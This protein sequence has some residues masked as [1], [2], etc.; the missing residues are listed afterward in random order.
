MHF[1]A[2]HLLYAMALLPLLF[3]LFRRGGRRRRKLL[4]TFGS[5]RLVRH[6]V[7][8]VDERRRARKERIFLLALAL[9]L[10]SLSQ[11]QYGE[12]QTPVRR[13]GI[14]IVFALDTSLSMLA[15]D[16]RPS[17]LERARMEVE[18]LLSRLDGDRVGIVS[19]AGKA[20]PTSPL[21]IDY[22]AVRMFLRG[23]DPWTVPT[24]GTAIAEA[25]RKSTR[26]LVKGGTGSKVIVVLTDGEDHE[27]KMNEAVE[28]ARK[29]GIRIFTIGIGTAEGELIPISPREYKKDKKGEFVVSHRNDSSL[30]GAAM[31]TG[32]RHLVLAEEPDALDQVLDDISGMTRREFTARLAVIREERFTW[33]L[34]PATVLLMIESMLTITPRRREEY[35]SGRIE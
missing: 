31:K 4:D 22:G 25:I 23:V 9:V 2:P 6:L 7:R 17:R 20:V 11:P 18:G 27:G 16:M 26:M 34:L 10:F 15:E 3:I 8:G 24:A 19:F 32:G 14:D 33:F 28:E 12:K 5:N 1:G 13:E 29:E 35:W 30:L 21:T